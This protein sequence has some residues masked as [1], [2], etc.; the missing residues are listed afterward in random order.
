MELPLSVVERADIPSLQPSGD[1]VEV[2]RVVADTPSG[3]AVLIRSR[4]LVC[5][6]VNA[7]IH[8]VVPADRAVVNDDVP[9]PQSDGVPLLHFKSNFAVVFVLSFDNFLSRG[10]DVHS[11]SHLV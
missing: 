9:S 3:V 5:L 2:E 11:V 10:V 1:A 4:H 7:K 8:D 6:T